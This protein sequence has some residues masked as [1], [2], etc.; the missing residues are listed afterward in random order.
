MISDGYG[1][2]L[3][4]DET[5]ADYDS[6]LHARAHHLLPSTDHRHDDLVQEGRIAMWKAYGQHDRAKGALPSWLTQHANWH[7][8][9]VISRGGKWT[10]SPP[11]SGNSG[12]DVKVRSVESLDAHLTPE[13]DH[14]PDDA[15]AGVAPD[16]ADQAMGAYHRGEIAEAIGLLSEAQQRYVR[17]RFAEDHR[18]AE[19]K[20]AFGYDPS[21]LWNSAKN[22]AK[23][24][25]RAHLSHLEAA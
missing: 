15:A 2:K 25:L 3:T 8:R 13:S 21:A 1:D 22:G 17:L 6:W 4:I 11:R 12:V 9:E 14:S 24:K 18:G 5:L 19:M 10:G 23:H 7:M 16:I 20:D